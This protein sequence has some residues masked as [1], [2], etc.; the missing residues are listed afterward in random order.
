MQ[1]YIVREVY[2]FEVVTSKIFKNELELEKYL[3]ND[4]TRNA[5]VMKMVNGKCVDMF[6]ADIKKRKVD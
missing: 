3:L 1:Q 5:Y 6:Y 2:K 4:L